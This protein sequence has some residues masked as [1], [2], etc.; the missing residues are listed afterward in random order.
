M[1]DNIQEVFVLVNKKYG[2]AIFEDTSKLAHVLEDVAPWL[3]SEIRALNTM[4]IKKI[5]LQLRADTSEMKE[6]AKNQLMNKIEKNDEERRIATQNC[7]YL[8]SDLVNNPSRGGMLDSLRVSKSIG[9]EEKFG[10]IENN[11]EKQD[12]N[13]REKNPCWK[14]ESNG[15]TIRVMS[16]GSGNE[17][18]IDY[19]IKNIIDKLIIE[20]GITE[21]PIE[22][23]SGMKEL[24][25]IVFPTTL[26]RIGY[27]SFENCRRLEKIILPVGLKTISSKAFQNCTCLKD[28]VIPETVRYI[29]DD[30]FWGTYG[31]K[32]IMNRDC[33][34]CRGNY[35]IVSVVSG[36]RM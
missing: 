10:T 36:K 4:S 5:G 17:I 6:K 30:A 20:E 3:Y 27:S 8:I 32:I 21:I 12:K 11:V 15:K 18:R 14:L 9:Q 25:E 29:G 16:F 19:E 7:I 31:K 24:K 35:P 34:V 28:I 22:A 33:V 26:V 13:Q 2:S 23:F 1:Q